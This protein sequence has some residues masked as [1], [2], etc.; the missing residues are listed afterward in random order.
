M[1]KI[2][3]IMLKGLFCLCLLGLVSFV[4]PKLVKT[5]L[6]GGITILLP[7][8]WQPMDAMDFTERY[9]S[10]RAPLAAYTDAERTVDLSIN[11][12]ATQWPDTDIEMAKGFFKATLFNV[13]DKVD[14]L[15][16]GVRES[17]G[18]KFI[19]FEFNSRVNGSKKEEGLREPVLKY[20]YIQYLI[21]PGRTLVFSFSSP[22]R[23]QQEWQETAREMMNSAR[24]K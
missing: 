6:A 16:E 15:S 2:K 8:D 5:K 19:Y 3:N 22:Q 21:E 13:F 9:P 20:S 11:I 12:S 10:V 23:K 14:I 1:R 7:K 4:K 18:K 17:N 24:V